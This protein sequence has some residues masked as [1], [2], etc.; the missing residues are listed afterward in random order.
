MVDTSIQKKNT[1]FPKDPNPDRKVI[2][3]RHAVV[4]QWGKCASTLY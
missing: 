3:Q 1:I 2:A 4:Q